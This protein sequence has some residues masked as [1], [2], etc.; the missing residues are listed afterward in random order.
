MKRALRPRGYGIEYVL[1]LAAV[2]EFS[3]NR[4]AV[5]TL[6]PAVAETPPLWHAVLDHVGLFFQYFVTM[7]AVGVVGVMAWR[8]VRGDGRPRAGV[9]AVPGTVAAVLLAGLAVLS[10]VHMAAA[11]SPT[12][13]FVFQ[14]VI[15]FT[16]LALALDQVTARG[17]IGAKIGVALLTIPLFI[18][19]YPEFVYY[20]LGDETVRWNGLPIEFAEYGKWSVLFMALM[21]PFLFAPRPFVHSVTRLPPLAVAGFVGVI[22]AVILRQHYEVGMELASK[23]VGVDI[24]PGA[25][26]THIALYVVALGAI[27]WTLV[28]TLSATTLSR[29]AIGVGVGL[30][31]LGG[32]AFAWPFQYLLGVAGLFTISEA[33]GAVR[34]EEREGESHRARGFRSPPIAGAV[35]QRYVAA[36]LSGLRDAEPA[37]KPA[38]V[39]VRGDE[40]VSSTHVVAVRRGIDLRVRVDRLH[41]SIL[42]I[43]IT[44]GRE[45][46]AGARP[47]WTLHARPDRVLGIRAHEEP[48]HFDGPI[49]RTEDDPFDARFRIRDGTELTARMFDEALRSRTTALID[50]WMACWRDRALIYRV[51]PGHGAPLDH[52]I[53]IT[54]LAFRGESAAPAV[55]RLLAVIDLVTSLAARADIEPAAD[56]DEPDDE[57]ATGASHDDATGDDDTTAN[58]DDQEPRA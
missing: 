55:A 38:S 41:D 54:E 58:R 45:P 39:T 57:A 11:G 7:L 15:A 24:G 31:V 33:A 56:D 47:D 16:L 14:L 1:L 44:C 36:L 4:L 10:V 19:F 21:S 30:V 51:F 37:C 43:D 53:P 5:T 25:P 9:A 3:L 35:W 17:D 2:V 40:D 49:I 34:R 18:H 48:P 23:G 6:R 26:D 13:S 20:L 22:G 52:P 32:Y 8:L 27:T 46:P 42:C 28:S 12:L 29:R 50:G